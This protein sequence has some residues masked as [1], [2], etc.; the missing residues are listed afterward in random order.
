MNP[1]PKC[2]LKLKL[3]E[4]K[5]SGKSSPHLIGQRCLGYHTK[6]TKEKE[7]NIEGGEY[8]QHTYKRLVHRIYKEPTT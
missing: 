2:K 3:L 6:Q 8:S 5:Q 4:K 7:G 1:K